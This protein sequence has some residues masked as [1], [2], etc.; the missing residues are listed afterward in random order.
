MFCTNEQDFEKIRDRQH[1]V[2]S[3]FEALHARSYAKKDLATPPSPK[4]TSYARPV[5]KYFYFYFCY[6]Y[7]I[8]LNFINLFRHTKVIEILMIH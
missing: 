3:A 5:V 1:R 7:I 6:L 4:R 8:Y 2:Q